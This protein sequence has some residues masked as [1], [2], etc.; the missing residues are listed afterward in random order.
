MQRNNATSSGPTAPRR[1][2]RF[3]RATFHRGIRLAPLLL[4]AVMLAAVAVLAE[5]SNPAQTAHAHEGDDH[6]HRCTSPPDESC[7]TYDHFVSGGSTLLSATLTLGTRMVSGVSFLG[8]ND[9][10]DFTEAS[11]TDQ[12]FTFGGDTYDVEQ[13]EF[14]GGQLALRFNIENAGDIATQAT[15]DKLTLHVGSDSF[16]FGAGTLSISQLAITWSNTG[17]HLVR[18]RFRLGEDN[19]GPNAQ[20]LRLPDHLDGADDGGRLATVYPV[21]V[22]QT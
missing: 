19:R 22:L 13:I 4:A 21:R 6:T 7:P 14:F 1:S 17:P 16:N 10:G 15:R 3:N 18:R 9:S 20:R 2:R 11:L 8:W 5:T 12:N